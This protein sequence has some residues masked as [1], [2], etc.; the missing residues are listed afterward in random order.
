MPRMP[1]FCFFCLS[2]TRVRGT[3]T[4][5][6]MSIPQSLPIRCLAEIGQG[7]VERANTGGVRSKFRIVRLPV[8][9]VSAFDGKGIGE[10]VLKR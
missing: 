8:E 10:S 9:P 2:L 5:A 7:G 6:S 1:R 4:K 3:E